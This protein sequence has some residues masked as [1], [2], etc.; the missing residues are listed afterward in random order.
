METIR[1][2]FSGM[3]LVFFAAIFLII[4]LSAVCF[5]FAAS[6]LGLKSLY[7]LF[8]RPPPAIR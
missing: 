4:P 5:T 7:V 2:V 8:R 6:A 1:T 3:V